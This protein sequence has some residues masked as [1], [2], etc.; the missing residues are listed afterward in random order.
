MIKVFKSRVRNKFILNPFFWFTLIWIVVL[1][2]HGLSISRTYPQASLPMIVF[3]VIVLLL[4]VV[5]GVVY[6]LVFLKK[7]NYSPVLN[8]RPSYAFIIFSFV[9]LL[10]EILYSKQVP[11]LGALRGQSNAYREFGI[12]GITFLNT[13]FVFFIS[14]ISSV[15]LIYGDKKNRWGNLLVFALCLLRFVAIYSRGSL[16]FCLIILVLVFASKHKIGFFTILLLVVLAIVAMRVFNALGN[17]RMGSPWNDSSIILK[18]A[19]VNS[20]Y[21]PAKDYIWTLI[22]IDS[23]IGNLL[24]NEANVPV[25]YNFAGLVS[26]LIPDFL[27]KRIFPNYDSSLYLA[28]PGL[29]VSSMFAGSYKYFGYLGMSLA[30]IEFVAFIFIT[31][32]IVRKNNK[33]LIGASTALSFIAIMSFFDNMVVYSGYSFYL[34]YIVIARFIEKDDNLLIRKEKIKLAIQFLTSKGENDFLQ[35]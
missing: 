18:L 33:Y 2:V 9:V 5:L 11:L 1:S 30:Y 32:L 12:G 20:Q 29:T 4:S 22:Y 24:Y 25:D 19:R 6:H 23:P 21:Y 13:T 31:S 26:Q 7:L 15:K 14:I 8:S 27:S 16:A 28:I 35:I 3:F 17:I 34:L 10:A